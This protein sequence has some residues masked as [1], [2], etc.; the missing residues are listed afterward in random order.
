MT[1][2]HAPARRRR[3][4]RLIAAAVQLM[5]DCGVAAQRVYDPIALADPTTGGVPVRRDLIDGLAE[6]AA[7]R[8]DRAAEEDTERWPAEAEQE[9]AEGLTTFRRRC[10]TAEADGLL[11][12]LQLQRDDGALGPVPVPTPAQLALMGPDLLAVDLIGAL[13][14]SEHEIVLSVLRDAV[15]TGEYTVAQILDAAKDISLAAACL[16]LRQAA[17]TPD[18]SLA[19]ETVLMATRSLS[20]AVV[21]AS[22]DFDDLMEDDRA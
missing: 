6:E 22:A 8:L 15:G 19:A 10:A 21:L 18:P 11:L 1:D 13:D 12:D 17:E 14:D 16:T 4:A 3:H 20:R 9:L 7:R 5:V 2:L